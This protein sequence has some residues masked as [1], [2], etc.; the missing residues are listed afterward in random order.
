MYVCVCAC[1][2]VV[3]M[4]TRPFLLVRIL[5]SFI[6]R[7]QSGTL[8]PAAHDEAKARQVKKGGVMATVFTGGKG[9]REN[10]MT[11]ELSLEMNRKMQSVLEDT[12]L[13]NI[14]LKVCV[15]VITYYNY[16]YACMLSQE[17]IDTLGREIQR[18]SARLQAHENH[19]R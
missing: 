14:T 3:F 6:I 10:E 18:L 2:R 4:C 5:Q 7:E 11:Y 19:G 15:I 9:Q 8:A 1:V 13:K 17:S 16:V 12:L